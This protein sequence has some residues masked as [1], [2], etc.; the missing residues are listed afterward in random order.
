MIVWLLLCLNAFQQNDLD[1]FSD[2]SRK[3]FFYFFFF[4][5]VR[6]EC[7]CWN[8]RVVL[9]SYDLLWKNCPYPQL[10]HDSI[11]IAIKPLSSGHS[12]WSVFL[13]AR[14][15]LWKLWMRIC[16]SK[17]YHRFKPLTQCIW[18]NSLSITQSRNI[19]WPLTFNQTISS[20]LWSE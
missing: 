4:F 16:K 8:W 7:I 12:H 6:K 2:F 19:I 17:Q 15:C 10:C 11:M 18:E 20:P 9:Q 14:G 3:D 5:F 1:V 13:M